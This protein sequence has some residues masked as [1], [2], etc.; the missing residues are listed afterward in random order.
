MWSCDILY[1]FDVESFRLITVS[2][3]EEPNFHYCSGLVVYDFV[4]ASIASI[5]IVFF[6]NSSGC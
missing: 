1:Y 6:Y 4:V 5:H 2:V 3:R